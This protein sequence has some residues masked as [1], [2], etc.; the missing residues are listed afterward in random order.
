MAGFGAMVFW[1]GDFRKESEGEWDREG[2]K[3]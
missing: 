2:S 3:V 1:G